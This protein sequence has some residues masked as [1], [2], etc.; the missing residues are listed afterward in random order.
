[1]TLLQAIEAFLQMAP[2]FLN[3][4]DRI[5]AS[6]DKNKL[7][8]FLKDLEASIDSITKAKTEDEKRDAASKLASTI[9]RL[10]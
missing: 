3:L 2:Q 7:M 6:W 5:L 8:L 1:M 10:R 4:A 9:S